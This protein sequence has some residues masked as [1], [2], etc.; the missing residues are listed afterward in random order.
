[1]E[2]ELRCFGQTETQMEDPWVFCQIFWNKKTGGQSTSL[3]RDPITEKSHLIGVTCAS[4]VDP[5]HENMGL[6]YCPW[7][8]EVILLCS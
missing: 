1:M 6:Q 2:L 7:K 4:P 5:N 3:K 8:K